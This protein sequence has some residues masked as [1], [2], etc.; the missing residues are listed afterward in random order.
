MS[1]TNK[2]DQVNE[3][4]GFDPPDPLPTTFTQ[5]M[6]PDLLIQ[7]KLDEERAQALIELG[8][9][10]NEEY[11]DHMLEWMQDYN[12]PVA[13][14]LQPYLARLGKPMVPRIRAVLE[15]DEAIWKYWCILGLI[16]EMPIEA[17][18]LLRPQLEELATNPTPS[19]REEEVDREAAKSLARLR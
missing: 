8:H 13:Q 10:R 3:D 14:V 6:T 18:R 7:E 16:N 5:G 1:S 11:L 2:A 19:D 9:P 15:G 12:W 17:A 4:S